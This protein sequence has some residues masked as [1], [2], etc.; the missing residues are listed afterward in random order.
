MTSR[1]LHA[2]LLPAEAGAG[3]LLAALS[4][5]L[6]GTGPALL[7][8]DPALPPGRLARLLEALAPSALQTLDGTERISPPASPSMPAAGAGD[9]AAVVI[10]TSGSTGEPKGV[11]L[12]A[13]ALRASAGASLARIGAGPGQRWLCCLPAFHVAGIGVLV[14]SLLAG[15]DPVISS[16]VDAGVIE[17]SGCSHVSLVPAQ[18]RRLLDAGAPLAAFGTILLGGAAPPPGLVA[19]AAAAGA[20]VVTTYGMSETCGGCIYD[21]LPLDGVSVDVEADGRIKIA[22]PVL[23][24]GYRLRPE[25]TRAAL[26]GGWF[27]T[28]DLGFLDEAGLL[29]VRGRADDL[30]NT[31]GEKV[32]PGEIEAVLG[33]MQAVR[34][35][36]IVGMPDRQWGELVT[37]FVV[38]ADPAA[39]PGLDEV[40]A[41]VRERLPAYAAPRQLFVLPAVP[42]LPSGKPDRSALRR[43]ASEEAPAGAMERHGNI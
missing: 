14:R 23:F 7:P 3:Q 29:R 35:V 28:S 6:D 36:V 15:T 18:L 10:A 30:I 13:A 24:S 4:A 8:L 11:E 22:G 37:A 12:T 40:R 39:V 25:L 27:R 5:A 41:H 9:D 19:E 43:L 21:G 32:V 20:R 16:R 26:S 31:G 2:V 1:P 42:L 33:T 17:A 34:D 38:P